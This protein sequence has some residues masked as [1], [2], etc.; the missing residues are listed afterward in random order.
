KSQIVRMERIIENEELVPVIVIQ[1][2]VEKTLFEKKKSK[3][4]ISE[5][6]MQTV[7]L[8]TTYMVKT[9]CCFNGVVKEMILPIMDNKNNSVSTPDSRNVND[10]LMRCLAKNIALFGI[11][12]ALYT[13]EDLEQFVVVDELSSL[14]KEVMKKYKDNPETKE[15]FK[16][17]SE[18]F[19]K[20]VKEF[21]LEEL[22]ELN[23]ELK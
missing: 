19:G 13:G 4:I 21:N 8:K 23:S 18:K 20:L 10:S 3:Q 22:K 9:K 17:F 15:T 1:D 6:V 11:G 14:K 7:E 16:K 5:D 12:L 2:G